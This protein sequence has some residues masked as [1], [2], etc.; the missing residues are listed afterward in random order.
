M[1][2]L[3]S[4]KYEFRGDDKANM[5][6]FVLFRSILLLSVIIRDYLHKVDLVQHGLWIYHVTAIFVYFLY[7]VFLLL[8]VVEKSR[9]YDFDNFIALVIWFDGLFGM[10]FF[11]L[12]LNFES[13]AY[14]FFT[15]PIILMSFRSDTNEVRDFVWFFV[16]ILMLFASFLFI[17]NHLRIDSVLIL[18][19]NLIPRAIFL[20]FIYFVSKIIFHSRKREVG[21]KNEK[22]AILNSIGEKVFAIDKNHRVQWANDRFLEDYEKKYQ[23][24][25]ETGLLCYKDFRGS[26]AKCSPCQSVL[27]MSDGEVHTDVEEWNEN[28]VITT[29]RVTAAPLLNKKGEIVGAVETLLDITKYIKTADNLKK[30]RVTRSLLTNIINSA[31]DSIIV[32][33]TA[34]NIMISNMAAAELLGLSPVELKKRKSFDIY[35]DKDGLNGYDIAVEVRGM[36]YQKKAKVINYN[37][38]FKSTKDE[39]IP[40]S[41]SAALIKNDAGEVQG[42]VGIGHDMREYNQLYE[43]KML[44]EKMSLLGG[45]SLE[46]GHKIRDYVIA[47]KNEIFG[48]YGIMD[49]RI[50]TGENKKRFDRCVSTIEF[51]DM[52]LEEMKKAAEYDAMEFIDMRIIDVYNVLKGHIGDKYEKIRCIISIDMDNC[53]GVVNTDY[54]RLVD[55]IDI[56]INNSIEAK[57]SHDISDPLQIDIE[58][59]CVGGFMC[60]I[61][62]DNGPGIRYDLRDRIFDLFISDKH[63]GWGIGLFI[64]KNIISR[65]RG[66]IDL[67]KKNEVGARFLINMPIKK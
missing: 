10:I 67:D 39:I 44:N 42:A 45:V 20:G 46:L 1:S 38:Y 28:G 16:L 23:K 66:T 27:A 58:F 49:E 2:S 26:D 43:E 15:L 30:L 52:R 51:I 41:L 17:Y 35:C 6:Y 64:A 29:Y 11:G 19:K 25:F 5:V 56:L 9:N 59:K 12:S 8:F 24:K 22:Y 21:F 4:F 65:H 55:V 7:I 13:D 3:W 63:S 61:V 31:V 33:D 62:A 57:N 47:L 54:K 36:L 50:F 53:K 18:Y 14:L 34:G 37:T 40:I 32:T 48:L 60:L